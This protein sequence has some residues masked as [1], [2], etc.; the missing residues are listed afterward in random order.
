[1]PSDEE[2]ARRS[3]DLQQRASDVPLIQMSGYTEW[4]EQKLAAGVSPALIANLDARSMWLLPEEVA[5]VS[6]D[7]FDELLNDLRGE[8]GDDE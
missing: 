5:T 7:I 1:M 4:S 8:N 6:T 3:L 2:I